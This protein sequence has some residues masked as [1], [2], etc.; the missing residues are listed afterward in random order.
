LRPPSP[1]PARPPAPTCN[2]CALRF[3][4]VVSFAHPH[5]INGAVV[6][7][8]G[9]AEWSAARCTTVHIGIGNRRRPGARRP[10]GR[11]AAYPNDR[12]SQ[13]AAVVAA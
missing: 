13:A 7:N 4:W 12:G 9:V 8:K 1:R 2:R 11:A 3:P 10:H 5:R 6:I